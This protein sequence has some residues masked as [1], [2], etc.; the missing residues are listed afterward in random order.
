MRMFLGM[1]LGC[2]MT[3]G[4]VYV[5]DVSATSTV[6]SNEAVVQSRPIVN[7]D[8]ASAKWHDV[9]EDVRQTW[10]KLRANIG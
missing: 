2:L 8:V 3:I 10:A 7:L 4:L 5:H 6:T 1:I 9:K